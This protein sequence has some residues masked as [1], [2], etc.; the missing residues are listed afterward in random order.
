MS[1]TPVDDEIVG[2]F[3]DPPDDPDIIVEATSEDL[4]RA[5]RESA[6]IVDVEIV[7]EPTSGEA[8]YTDAIT[9]PGSGTAT[10]D[11][12]D[13][14]LSV[15]LGGPLGSTDPTGRGLMSLE[16]AVEAAGEMRARE[17]ARIRNM[18]RR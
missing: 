8:E 5:Q 18:R 10:L 1:H 3:D 15:E 17:A 12:G 13:S 6:Q 11:S 14:S 7:A 2:E 16:Q 4:L 9:T